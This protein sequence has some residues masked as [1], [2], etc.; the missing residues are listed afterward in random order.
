MDTRTHKPL[1]RLLITDLDNTLWDWFN[2]WHHSF[3]AML[4]KLSHTSGIPKAQLEPEIQAV[5]RLRGTA[6]YSCLLN[7]LPSLNATSAGQEPMVLYDDAMHAM[8]SARIRH[9]SLYPGVK[10]TI[11]LMRQQRLPIVAY[12]ESLAYW[13]EWRIKTTSLDGLIDVL[14][15][16]PDHD[17]PADVTRDDIRRRPPDDY[18]LKNTDHRTVQ[19]G[20]YKPNPAI[21][22]RI[23]RDYEVHP[24]E[25][26]YVGDSLMKDMAMAQDVGVLDVHAAYGVAQDR[27]GYDLLR[28]VSHWSEDDIARERRLAAAPN[29]YPTYSLHETFAELLTLFDFE[30]KRHG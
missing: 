6:E 25:A 21:L 3:S 7:E 10:H 27:E 29:V 18:G 16:S 22:K 30:G 23:L 8:H 14:Y 4:E 5:H 26:V 11:E 15:T 20:T 13:T 12:S 2:A 24:H 9:T 1:V 17:F 28:R 19:V